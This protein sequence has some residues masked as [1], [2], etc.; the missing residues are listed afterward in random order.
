V[1]RAFSIHQDTVH[2]LASSP[3]INALRLPYLVRLGNPDSLRQDMAV[4]HLRRPVRFFVRLLACIG[5]YASKRLAGPS[6]AEGRAAVSG[7]L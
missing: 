1:A 7:A 4:E 5:P 6:A 2:A 3:A